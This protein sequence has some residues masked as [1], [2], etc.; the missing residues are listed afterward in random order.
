MSKSNLEFID[1]F[2]H[3]QNNHTTLATIRTEHA[4]ELVSPI[5]GE[6]D[7]DKFSR[8]SDNSDRKDMAK[9]LFNDAIKQHSERIKDLTYNLTI[10][11]AII[12]G[13]CTPVLQED[14]NGDPA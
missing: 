5:S 7:M 10:L 4:L 9:M 12:M 14:I 1:P 8:E 2:V 3:L 6:S 13:Q 11:W